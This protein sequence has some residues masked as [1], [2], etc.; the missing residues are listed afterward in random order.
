MKESLM[1]HALL[2]MMLIE[3]RMEGYSE[4][5]TEGRRQGTLAIARKWLRIWG[6]ERFGAPYSQT[7]AVI[8]SI[9]D[10]ERLEAL[11]FRLDEA[12][13]W[14]EL[15]GASVGGSRKGRRRQSS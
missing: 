11:I 12:N 8:E 3:A 9:E 5:F 14:Q 7:A 2:K 10:L 6:D 4:G 1:D 15:L 13:S